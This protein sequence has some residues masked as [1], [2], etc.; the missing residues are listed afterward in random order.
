MLGVYAGDRADANKKLSV[1]L[2]S[3][4]LPSEEESL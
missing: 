4:I 3:G 2:V 1:Y